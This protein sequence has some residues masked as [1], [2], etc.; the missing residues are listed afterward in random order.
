MVAGHAR[1]TFALAS[2]DEIQYHFLAGNVPTLKEDMARDEKASAPVYKYYFSRNRDHL[3]SRQALEALAGAMHSQPADSGN[4]STI[5]AGYTYLMQFVFH[6]ISRFS[7]ASGEPK[8]QTSAALDMKSVLGTS[9]FPAEH[10]SENPN[11]ALRIGLTLND[12]G[13]LEPLPEDLPRKPRYRA[14]DQPGRKPKG[15]PL[16]PDVRN[17]GFL[18]LNQMH[19]L[20][21]QFFNAIA[22][23]TGFDTPARFEEAER[24]F[25]QHVQSVVLHDLLPMLTDTDVH[26]DVVA[27]NER[28]VIHPGPVTKAHPFW[29]PME[30]AF[31]VARFGHSMV[32]ENYDWNDVHR[33]DR[34]A[35]L[36][37]LVTHSHLNGYPGSRPLLK[38]E[39]NWVID[40]KRFFDVR[41][42]AGVP[43]PAGSNKIGP[44]LA[45]TMGNLPSHLAPPDQQLASATFDL[46]KTTL[47]RQF[48]LELATAQI[49][50]AM[51]NGSL[52]GRWT[53]DSLTGDELA[54]DPAQPI[55]QVFRQFPELYERT[56]LWFY[57]LREAE[58]KGRGNRLGMLGSRILAEVLHAAIEASGEVA[59]TRV[60][61]WEPELPCR[62]G[63]FKM[64]DL[65]S[66]AS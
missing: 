43:G 52:S 45:E 64:A 66:Y 38:L 39:R 33:H 14:T 31:A 60:P 25:V 28:R 26:A 12:Y 3:P 41:S 5:P 61:D 53:I 8:N 35:D 15:Y 63:R 59:I 13:S 18:Q 6:D 32:R 2:G 22:R 56:P 24:T 50:L 65:I 34:A 46:A 19:V 9:D 40:W 30:F 21:L 27:R 17:E 54:G 49:V 16:M 20:F 62:D 55:G 29:I 4:E 47:L 10:E 48:D 42:G 57:I 23:R 7:L 1:S 36:L 51:A 37:G 44:S 58:L 11:N